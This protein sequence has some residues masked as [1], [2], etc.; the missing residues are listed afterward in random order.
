MECELVH[1]VT[2]GSHM[3]LTGEVKNIIADENILNDN[4]KIMMPS[5]TLK[6]IIFSASVLSFIRAHLFS[7]VK[8]LPFCR[9]ST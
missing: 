8:A 9:I 5:A 7:T 6:G 4:D 1:S 3:Q 2:V